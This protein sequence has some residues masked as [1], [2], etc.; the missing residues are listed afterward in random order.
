MWPGG[1]PP[2]GA[3]P[4]KRLPSCSIE[5]SV[6]ITHLRIL[7]QFCDHLGRALQVIKVPT[8]EMEFNPHMMNAKPSYDKMLLKENEDSR[9]GD[10]IR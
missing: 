6:D 7:E 10:T 3:L 5:D 9:A 1:P 4:R 2:S 8:P